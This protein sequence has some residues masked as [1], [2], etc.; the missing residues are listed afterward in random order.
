[1]SASLIEAL[2]QVS[3]FRIPRGRRS[4]LELVLLLVI[5]GTLSGCYGY[6]A[7]ENFAARHYQAFSY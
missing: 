3:D 1:M 7:L 6:A 5:M 4:P 2:S